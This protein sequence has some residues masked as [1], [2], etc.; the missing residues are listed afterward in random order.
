M[1]DTRVGDGDEVAR[2]ANPQSRNGVGLFCPTVWVGGTVV[3]V[4]D[5]HPCLGAGKGDGAKGAGLCVVSIGRIRLRS[6]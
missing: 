3:E 6:K 1:F 5:G 2:M 4:V